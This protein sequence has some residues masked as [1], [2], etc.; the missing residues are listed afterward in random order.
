MTRS[1][2]MSSDGEVLKGI[3]NFDKVK[4]TQESGFPTRVLKENAKFFTKFFFDR[5]IQNSKFYSEL[6]LADM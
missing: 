6:K 5:I 3:R 2:D 4:K 1:F